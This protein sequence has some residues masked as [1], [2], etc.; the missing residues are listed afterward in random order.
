MIR[1]T[2]TMKSF[3][4]RRNKGRNN[5]PINKRNKI[6]PKG[7][8]TTHVIIDSISS[9][10]PLQAVFPGHVKCLRVVIT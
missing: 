2:D 5:I 9:L 3:P 4:S 1:G 8:P 7:T 10:P 6:I